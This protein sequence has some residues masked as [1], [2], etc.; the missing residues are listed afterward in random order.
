MLLN[1]TLE[2]LGLLGDYV[3]I[4]DEE[5]CY[6]ATNGILIPT[7]DYEPDVLIEDITKLTNEEWLEFR[8]GKKGQYRRGGSGAANTDPNITSSFATPREEYCKQLGLVEDSFH[9][10]YA[11]IRGHIM[12]PLGREIL[13]RQFKNCKIFELPKMFQHP[14]YKWLIAD[15]D[16]FME[17]PQEDGSKETVIVEIK[18][19]SELLATNEWGKN[20]FTGTIPAK[21]VEQARQYM[22]V[23]GLNR[24]V[25]CCVYGMGEN[26]FI[27]R[28]VDR[29]FEKEAHLI[30]QTADFVVHLEEEEIPEA[31][32]LGERLKKEL[33]KTTPKAPIKDTI[34]LDSDEEL[35]LDG[36]SYL[37]A[38]VVED[39]ISLNEKLE[40]LKLQEKEISSEIAELEGLVFSNT[41][42]CP[43]ELEGK[44]KI[45][46]GEYKTSSV[47]ESI[48]IRTIRTEYPSIYKFL[49]DEGVIKQSTPKESFKGYFR[50]K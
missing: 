43:F 30:E 26:D 42:G 22:A 12:E 5:K 37:V 15:C 7:Q 46:V 31:L 11:L 10:D 13:S 29:D 50:A 17:I 16:G 45:F 38:E 2:K 28:S 9:S 18:T 40:E 1:P 23:T 32:S 41:A 20:D 35:E 33:L 14:Y 47:R 34:E 19:T 24:T 21:Y 3:E 27:I 49:K 48:P 6:K 44:D 39:L 8:R 25:F 4:P 36:K